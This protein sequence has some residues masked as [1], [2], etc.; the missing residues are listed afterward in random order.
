MTHKGLLRVGIIGA[1]VT[2]LCCF[3]PVLVVVLGAVGLSAAI[4]WLDYVLWPALVLFLGLTALAL[5]R[6][7]S[8]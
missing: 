5:W 3:T 7:R 6:R 8:A 2:A 1:V 4:G